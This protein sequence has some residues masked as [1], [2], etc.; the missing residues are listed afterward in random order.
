ML[1]MLGIDAGNS[2]IKIVGDEGELLIP[3]ALGEYRERKLYQKFSDNDIEYKYKKERGFAGTLAQYESQL[4]ASQMGDSKAHQE[5]VIRVLIGITQYTQETI[6]D[7]VV[8]QPIAKHNQE[9]KDKMKNMLQGE[10]RIN[11]NGVERY[12]NICNVEIASEGG[13]AFWSNPVSGVI[14][15]MDIGGGTVNAATLNEAR[16][17]DKESFTIP[18]GMDTL[19]NNDLEALARKISLHALRVW[20]KEDALLICGGG[21]KSLKHHI[22]KYFNNSSLLCPF[23]RVVGSHGITQG[24]QLDP[25]FA[26]A[27][28]FYNMAKKVFNNVE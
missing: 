6:F 14:R 16:Y 11:I 5:M 18:E 13:S 7:I 2:N 15:I 27:V 8:G 26:N 22:G 23:L 1:K 25:V 9:E 19:L 10:H 17:I 21:S 20:D 4:L 24:R 12:I 28:G 3:S